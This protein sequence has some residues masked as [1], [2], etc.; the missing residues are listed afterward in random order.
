MSILIVF[1]HYLCYIRQENGQITAL[2]IFNLTEKY[3]GNSKNVK[4]NPFLKRV[5]IYMFDDPHTTQAN[6]LAVVFM[7]VYKFG[8][9]V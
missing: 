9:N 5:N 2:L 1:V 7:R 3:E 6:G 8:Q 4:K